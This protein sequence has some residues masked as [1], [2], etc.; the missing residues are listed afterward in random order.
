M[1]TNIQD[2]LRCFTL[3][4]F[5]ISDNYGEGFTFKNDGKDFITKG[6]YDYHNKEYRE[7]SLNITSYG[8]QHYYARI[9]IGVNNIDMDNPSHSIL[10]SLREA[11]IP[12]NCKS[13]DLELTRKVTSEEKE[14]FPNRWG[15]YDVGEPTDAFYSEEDIISLFK[16]ILP[17]ML[18]G[19]WHVGIRAFHTVYSE[20]FLVEY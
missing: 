15:G 6:T 8:I 3:D 13:L 2:N 19:K 11:G 7:I 4:E 10:G 12:D 17:N 9:F 20:D 5:P 14:N 16:K 1:D 18:K